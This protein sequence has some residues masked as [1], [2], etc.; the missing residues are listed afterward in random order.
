MKKL[1][2]LAAST[3]IM[4][5][6]TTFIAPAGQA[7][8]TRPCVTRAEYRAV[9]SGMLKRQV[10]RIWDGRGQVAEGGRFYHAC[11][12]GYAGVDYNFTS[13]TRVIGKWRAAT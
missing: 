13:P 9:H 4:L 11:G 10:L 3:T 7:M 8:D 5:G 6:G 12:G 2:A 1:V